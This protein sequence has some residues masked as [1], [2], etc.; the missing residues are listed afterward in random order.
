MIS[1]FAPGKQVSSPVT[2]VNLR[3]GLA[4]GTLHEFN[5]QDS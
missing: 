4:I 3:L 5:Q 2:Q 1:A